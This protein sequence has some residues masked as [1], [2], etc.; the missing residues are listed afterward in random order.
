ML[1]SKTTR[2]GTYD[3]NMNRIGD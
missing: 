2:N 3:V 1:N